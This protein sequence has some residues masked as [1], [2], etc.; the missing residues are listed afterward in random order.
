MKE[1]LEKLK[2]ELVKKLHKEKLKEGL[3]EML[4]NAK[5]NEKYIEILQEEGSVDLL[6]EYR[7]VLAEINKIKNKLSSNK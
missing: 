2:E 1:K 7:G 6:K 5:I 3:I 4:Q